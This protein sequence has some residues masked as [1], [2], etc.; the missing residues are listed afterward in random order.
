M[1]PFVSIVIPAFNEERYIAR[2][3]QSLAKLDYPRDRFDIRVIDNGS[4]DR[5]AEICR[6]HGVEVEVLERC[7]VGAVRNHG[8]AE[9]KGEI[10]A[11]VDSDC[12]VDPR[13]LSA[14]VE[15]LNNPETGAVGGVYLVEKDACWV[16]KAWITEQ[17]SERRETDSLAGGS[18]IMRRALFE[19]LGG[20][21]TSLSAGE[22]D[23]L[24]HRVQLAGYKVIQLKDCAVVHLGYPKTLSGTM[25]RQMW[26][27]SYQIESARSLSDKL[28]WLTHLYT[29]AGLLLIPTI[30][31]SWFVPA[32]AVVALLCALSLLGIPGLAATHRLIKYEGNRL[33]LVKLAQLYVIYQAYFVGRMFGLIKNYRRRWFSPRNS[34]V[35]AGG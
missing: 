1:L 24:S 10:V 33:E 5:T 6:E 21:D 25:R 17:V 35:G 3:L 29:L 30:L 13:W 22:D 8:V 12:E 28:L 14:A 32:M 11:F 4:Q 27:G 34:A 19:E 7:L 26:H 16:E 15:E 2:C 9:S 18:F 31:A 23:N 20:F